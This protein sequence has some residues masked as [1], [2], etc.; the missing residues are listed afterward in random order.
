MVRKILLCSE[1]PDIPKGLHEGGKH[2]AGQFQ[3]VMLYRQ[4]QLGSNICL[5]VTSISG[6]IGWWHG[7]IYVREDRVAAS[8]DD[9]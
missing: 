5:A 3:R 4:K 7:N 8:S 6:G 1:F 9:W 2:I